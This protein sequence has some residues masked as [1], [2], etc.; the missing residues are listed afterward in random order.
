MV[1]LRVAGLS[2][3]ATK[4]A[5]GRPLTL[6]PVWEGR[7]VPEN[8]WNHVPLEADVGNSDRWISKGTSWPAANK[9][10]RLPAAVGGKPRKHPRGEPAGIREC[11]GGALECWMLDNYSVPPCRCRWKYC[12]LDQRGYFRRPCVA[13]NERLMEIPTAYTESG[14]TSSELKHHPRGSEEV[15]VSVL[16]DAFRDEASSWLLAHLAVDL[17]YLQMLP[18]FDQFRTGVSR[19]SQRH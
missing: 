11:E 1:P 5:L 8:L 12:V 17:G 6:L 3:A 4:V 16:G 19:A 7:I 13:E 15:R 2:N 10:A 18:D 9:R 14:V